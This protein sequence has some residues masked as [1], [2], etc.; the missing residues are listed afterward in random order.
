MQKSAPNAITHLRTIENCTINYTF[1]RQRLPTAETNLDQPMSF[2]SSYQQHSVGEVSASEVS[3]SK[4]IALW[5]SLLAIPLLA[6]VLFAVLQPVKVLPRIG[7]APGFIFTDM[8]GEHLSNEDLRGKM[9]V[10]NFSTTVCEAPCVDTSATMQ[11]LQRM[12]QQLDTGG[13]PVMLVTMM[14][15]S[16]RATPA[17]LRAYA[18]RVGADPA[19]WRIITGPADRLKQVVGGGFGLYYQQKDDG[20]IE[21]AP[22]IAL[23]DGNGI[24]RAQYK[25]ETPDIDFV[26][27]DL[28][29]MVEEVR[30]S[31]G[32][33]S[34]VYEA[35]HLFA[36]YVTY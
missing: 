9:V 16:E 22:M 31:T 4:L 15:D 32:A 28:K 2:T 12:V 34:L 10:Y 14:L 18:E 7:L 26:E 24:L 8:N 35:A 1:F 29:L 21:Y 30:N 13:I 19:I 6:I 33:G 27:R 11:E 17:Q 3:N 25:R 20:V 23:V 5:L 36:C